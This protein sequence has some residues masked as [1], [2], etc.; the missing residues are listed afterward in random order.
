MLDVTWQRLRSSF[1]HT[2]RTLRLVF[3][4]APKTMV[5]LL[6]LT[7][8]SAV[9]PI[10]IAWVGKQIVDAVVAS[11]R[12]RTLHWVLVE[13]AIVI[14]QAA[15]LRALG[16][17]RSL[18]GAR[19]SI[20]INV[21][22]LNKALTLELTDFESSETYDRL[23]RARR[24]ASSRPLS[25]VNES[26]QLVQ[27]VLTLAGYV[28][29]LVQF[30]W[31]ATLGL[32][33]AAVPAAIVEMRFSK[34]AFRLRNWRSPES[35]QLNYLEYVIANDEHVKEVKLFGLGPLFLDRYRALAETFYKEDGKLARRRA[36]WA[37]LLSLLGTL[38]FYGAY[39][40]MALSAAAG[41]ITLGTMT[42]Y[43][44]AFRQGQQ[45]FQSIL[46]ALGGMYE[47]NLYM[48]NLF[49]FL[50]IERGKRSLGPFSRSQGLGIRFEDVGFRYPGQEGFALRHVNLDVSAG[51]SLALVGQNG[52]GKTTL[53]K[54]LTGL[55]APSEGRVTID[56][57][58]VQAWDREALRARMSV[59]F[60]DF[61]QYQLKLQENVGLGDV[62]HMEEA[63]RLNRAIE[64]GGAEEIVRAL[65][66]G[67]SA[68]LGRW[69]KDGVELSGGQW[70]KIAIARA[71]MRE[72]SDIL[73]L[74]EPTAAL[75][76][77]AEQTVFERFRALTKGRTSILIS[78]RF[79]TV[80]MADRIIVIEKGAIVESGSH[81]ALVA[82]GG[83]YAELFRLQARGYL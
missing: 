78:H 38:A 33:V 80:R 17:A 25:V 64:R 16:L 70:Q 73:I 8:V 83:R 22:I 81:E 58:D 57:L 74:D 5:A 55:Y 65:P 71:F 39:A 82:R 76:A 56:G 49:D 20:D 18:M 46:S 4:S 63:A 41:L 77:E 27:N 60:Q 59:V 69:F 42:L 21:K 34:L 75:D 6:L 30:S 11:D 72:E 23:T 15:T 13:L 45:A 40:S 37:L 43:V 7:L 29:L 51:E 61:N 44:I 66:Q 62:A 19:L 48:S 10:A 26:F 54:L 2:P 35:R 52:S 12:D 67:L 14:G 31:L 24:E 1:T 68:Q 36:A 53:I 79:P 50:A 32:V 47:D 3:E 28:V 9:L